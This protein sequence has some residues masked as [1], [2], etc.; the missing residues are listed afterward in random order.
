MVARVRGQEFTSKANDE[1]PNYRYYGRVPLFTRSC[2][3]FPSASSGKAVRDFTD[4]VRCTANASSGNAEL[5][6]HGL[7][8]EQPAGQ[9]I[10]VERTP[11]LQSI[12]LPSPNI[13][14]RVWLRREESDSS[15]L[16]Q[17][18]D[19]SRIVVAEPSWIR[20]NGKIYV[21]FPPEANGE[22]YQIELEAQ[23]KLIKPDRSGWQYLKI[24]GL[25][26]N[27][28]KETTGGFE[29]IIKPKFDTSKLP[30]FQFDS[31]RLLDSRKLG[32]TEL[33]SR[34]RLLDPLILGLR[35]KESVCNIDS[36]NTTVTLYSVPKWSADE[37]TQMKHHACL[38]I[39][40]SD[41]DIFTEKVKFSII[42]KYGPGRN[43]SLDTDEDSISLETD[44]GV[45]LDS[46]SKYSE[47][48][49]T[50]VRSSQNLGTP[51]N[52]YF[53][54]SY[55]D[56]EHVTI[57]MPSFRP[58]AGKVL[59]ERTVLLK[60]SPPIFLDYLATGQFSTWRMT[61]NYRGEDTWMFIDRV[62][63]P[64]LFPDGLKDNAMIRV[65]K[66][67]PVNYEGLEAL[68]RSMTPEHPSNIVMDLDIRIER[69]LGETLECR[70]GLTLQ[71]GNSCRLLTIDDQ[72]WT[73]KFFV[74]DGALATEKAGEWR[75]NE[76]GYK[77]LFKS[78][79]MRIGQMVRLEMHWKELV[80]LDEFK[81]E[82]VEKN[83]IEYQIPTVLGKVILGGTLL[84]RID[85]GMCTKRTYSRSKDCTDKVAQDLLL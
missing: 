44:D 65:R 17:N 37:G 55:A 78:S 34:F 39:D 23:V 20:E 75:E 41:H 13:F 64:P 84:C 5:T 27:E 35:S 73:P 60:T 57:N 51:I 63:V 14:P 4:M 36:W 7:I 49:I 22:S 26:T 72:D 30:E 46:G 71:V 11:L 47:A 25:P 33:V 18:S 56:V 80:I 31:N 16:I 81:D 6:K 82:G 19:P 52:F 61:E 58:K 12:R 48:E 66:L 79:S 83:R 21:I 15:I 85:E 40:M 70:M 76:D 53:T 8:T 38:A 62:E 28:G 77:T 59:S 10:Y 45:N 67:S 9:F 32:L 1:I 69:I 43:Y 74:I 68:D 42:A 50:I 2:L 29:F 3:T 54:L 24:L